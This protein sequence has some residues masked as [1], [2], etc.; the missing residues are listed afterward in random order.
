MCED[1]NSTYVV[2]ETVDGAISNVFSDSD[3][4]NVA[5]IERNDLDESGE[6]Y[7]EELMGMPGMLKGTFQAD[8][9]DVDLHEMWLS[10]FCNSDDD[11]NG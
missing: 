3:N 2:I 6:G 10:N 8:P 1:D 9:T 11:S 5:I 4:V 7:F